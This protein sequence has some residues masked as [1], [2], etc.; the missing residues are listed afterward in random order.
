MDKEETRDGGRGGKGNT[1]TSQ[2]M[3][4]FA[5]Y[6]DPADASDMGEGGRRVACPRII[7]HQHI[8]RSRGGGR[9]G[10]LFIPFVCGQVSLTRRGRLLWQKGGGEGRAGGHSKVSKLGTMDEVE[11]V[12]TVA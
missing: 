7:S 11:G 3:M 10:R 2:I 9:Y 1:R 6:C 12:D 5:C 4:I 8:L